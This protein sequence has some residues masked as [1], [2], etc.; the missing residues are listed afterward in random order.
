MDLAKLIASKEALVC[1]D[2]APMHIGIGVNTKVL[3]IFGPTDEKKLIPQNEKFIAIKNTSCS[4]RPCLW[5]KRNTTCSALTC[6]E[7]PIDEI[8]KQL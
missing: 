7:I 4:C 3:A 8:L 2:S 5:D 6:L 1:C